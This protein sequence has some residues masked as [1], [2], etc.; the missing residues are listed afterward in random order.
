MTARHA[1]VICLTETE[2]GG[3]SNLV[4]NRMLETKR[5]TDSDTVFCAAL[6]YKTLERQITL[7][8][9]LD[10]CLKKPIETLDTIVRAILRSGLCQMLYMDS[11]PGFAAVNESVKLCSRVKKKSAGALVNAALRRAMQF[12]PDKLL[13]GVEGIK[14]L[15]VAYS[16]NEA[17]CELLLAQYGSRTEEILK[18]FFTR[19]K[20]VLRVNSLKT[21][22]DKAAEALGNEG[23]ITSPGPVEG[24]LLAE[25]GRPLKSGAF[26]NGLIRPQSLAAQTAVFALSPRP[27]DKLIDLCAAPG[28]KSLTAAQIM[29]NTGEITAVDRHKNRLLLVERRAAKEGI[30]IVATC[31][32]DSSVFI[33]EYKNSADRVIADVPCSGYGE[34]YSKPELR[35]KRPDVNDELRETQY[36]ILTNGAG[37]LKERGRLVYSTCT[38]DKRE[39]QETAN[40]FLSENENFHIVCDAEFPGFETDEQGCYTKLPSENDGEGFFIAVFERKR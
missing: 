27:G 7:D 2:N 31:Q 25:S 6:F 34:I 22:G 36:K 1:A 32:A 33:S 28:G 19:G 24:S 38:L 11:V 16:V 15:S 26:G 40:R 4:L 39:N 10:K 35:Y 30:K 9:I 13:D 8:Y 14:A 18:G 29:E 3:Y 23:I 21:D 12:R 17:L 5:I 37:Y 20:Q